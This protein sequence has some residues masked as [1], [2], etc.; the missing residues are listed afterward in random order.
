MTWIAVAAGGALGSLA[1][2]RVNHVVMQWFERTTPWATFTVNVVGCFIIGALAGQIASGRLQLTPTMR[3]F[4]FVGVL[5]GFTTFSSF[6]L[7]TFTL[8]HGGNHAAAAWNVVGQVGL[9]LGGVWLG[10]Y[11]GLPQE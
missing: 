10:F 2:H 1:R 11:L 9:G 4:V 7:D 3:T 6:G 5:G 8:G